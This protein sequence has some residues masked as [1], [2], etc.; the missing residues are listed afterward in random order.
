MMVFP[1]R[2]IDLFLLQRKVKATIYVSRMSQLYV[3]CG[4]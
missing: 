3:D 4:S 1:G 2:M